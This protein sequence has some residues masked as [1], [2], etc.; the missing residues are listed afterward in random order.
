MYAEKIGSLLSGLLPNCTGCAIA[1]DARCV[2][3][4]TFRCYRDGSMSV[5]SVS[6]ACDKEVTTIIDINTLAI[7][8]DLY[9]NPAGTTI[10]IRER[11][12]P[13]PTQTEVFDAF[14]KKVSQQVHLAGTAIALD[15]QQWPTG[16]YFVQLS[17]AQGRLMGTGSFVKH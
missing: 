5:Q 14:G 4:D 8:L 11:A 1:L 7:P 12:F 10:S 6:N 17:R 13:F 9:P 2:Q 3:P 15:L 16:L